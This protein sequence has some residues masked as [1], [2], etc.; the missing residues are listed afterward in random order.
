MKITVSLRYPTA[1][2]IV[3]GKHTTLEQALRE[4]MPNVELIDVTQRRCSIEV[5]EGQVH[6]LRTWFSDSL[7]FS[8]E[9]SVEPF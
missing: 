5:S 7:L 1:P 8:P 3:G 4:R 2:L 9:M 6:A